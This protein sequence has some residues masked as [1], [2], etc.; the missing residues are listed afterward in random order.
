MLKVNRIRVF[1]VPHQ[2]ATHAFTSQAH[3][4][5]LGIAK[6][7]YCDPNSFAMLLQRA[8]MQSA[9][10][11]KLLMAVTDVDLLRQL[12]DDCG[13]MTDSPPLVRPREATRDSRV[14]RR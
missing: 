5:D 4:A 6:P 1:C 7:S 14:T 8:A 3:S 11:R 12:V 10:P 13:D 2:R 9:P